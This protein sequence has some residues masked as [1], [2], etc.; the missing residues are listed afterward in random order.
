MICPIRPIPTTREPVQ[1]EIRRASLWD[2]DQVGLLLARAHRRA[3]G[4]YPDALSWY[5]RIPLIRAL[6]LWIAGALLVVVAETWIT[7]APSACLAI[8]RTGQPWR[9]PVDRLALAVVGAG[10]GAGVLA[11]LVAPVDQALHAL[12]PPLAAELV[13]GAPVLV[14]IGFMLAYVAVELASNP[15]RK[16]R[17]RL[18]HAL[19]EPVWHV[20]ALA[21]IE[22]GA[23][24]VL[25]QALAAMADAEAA[26]LLAETDG[27]A[28]VR[29]YRAAGFVQVAWTTRPWGH[30]AVLVRVP[31]PTEPA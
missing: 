15:L 24:R 17:E 18:G 2:A 5:V 1:G 23:G 19:A 27:R 14:L 16:A 10:V 31:Q 20:E 12:L 28:R 11:V 4:R 7:G 26:T 21:S 22:P 25:G 13:F 8:R 9:F 6:I 29:L 30:S 3:S